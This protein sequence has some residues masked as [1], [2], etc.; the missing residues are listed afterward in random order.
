MNSWRVLRVLRVLRATAA[1]RLEVRRDAEVAALGVEAVRVR[2]VEGEL[3]DPAVAARG[4]E[5]GG[6]AAR[7]QRL[8]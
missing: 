5:G 2:A 3:D 8:F 4:D 1:Y 7:V 6:A